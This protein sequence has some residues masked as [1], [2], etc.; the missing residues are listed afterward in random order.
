MFPFGETGESEPVL[1]L[2][3]LAGGAGGERLRDLSLDLGAGEYLS[4]L[5]PSGTGKT[6][7]LLTIAGFFP[8][9]AGVMLLDGRGITRSAPHRRGIGLV[10]AGEALFPHMD[11][12]ANVGFPLAVRR[13]GREERRRRLA[14]TLDRLGLGAVAHARP[15]QLSRAERI[16]VGLARAIVFGPRLL[17]LDDPFA[18][19]DPPAAR[20]MRANLRDIARER[21][22]AVIHATRDPAEAMALA[23]RVAL[24]SGGRFRQVGTPAELYDRPQSLFV[25]RFMGETNCLPGR[26]ESIEDD[27]AEVRLEQ[28]GLVEALLPETATPATGTAC[29]VAVR[30][31]RVAMVAAAAGEMGGH[32]L[33]GRIGTVVEMGDHV[34]YELALAGAGAGRMVVRRPAGASAGSL[35]AGREV[36]LAWQPHHA[37]LFPS[38]SAVAEP[39]VA[40]AAS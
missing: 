24:L 12:A 23:D 1:R 19:L 39:A 9:A 35:A 10:L 16:R 3:G 36:A 26:I 34:R 4:L 8:A 25:A 29:V 20:Q 28:G 15:A 7:L 30:P 38:G 5:G 37:R 17:L 27:A 32:A 22:I 33:A 14:Q 13:M 6:R 18:P 11:V 40:V 21:D 2:R 31:E